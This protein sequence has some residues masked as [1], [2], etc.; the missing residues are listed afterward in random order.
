MPVHADKQAQG[1]KHHSVANELSQNAGDAELSSGF[2]D[3]RP[4]AI[5]QRKLQK[6]IGQKGSGFLAQHPPKTKSILPIQGFPASDND[7]FF[8]IT[9][10]TREDAATFYGHDEVVH[11]ALGFTTTIREHDGPDIDYGFNDGPEGRRATPTKTDDSNEGTNDSW[12]LAEGT[13]QV[14]GV[15]VDNKDLYVILSD[16]IAADVEAA[17]EE[18]VDDYRYAKEQILDRADAWLGANLGDRHFAAGESDDELEGQVDAYINNRLKP[19][20]GLTGVDDFHWANILAYYKRAADQTEKR[21]DE[22][23]HSFGNEDEILGDR[24]NRTITTGDSEVGTHGSADV[25]DLSEVT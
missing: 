9:S 21:D 15:Q 13:H 16:E 8:A 12:S 10:P 1:N 3:N 24:I 19:H 2:S 17:E 14:P 7:K 6:M 5:A 23:W 18:H 22:G 20:L 4:E 11:P 25:V